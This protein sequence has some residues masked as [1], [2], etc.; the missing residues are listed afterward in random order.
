MFAAHPIINNGAIYLGANAKNRQTC[1]MD[2]L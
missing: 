1:S 2:G